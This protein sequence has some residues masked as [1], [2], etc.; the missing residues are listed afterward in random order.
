MKRGWALGGTLCACIVQFSE[1]AY[2]DQPAWN[3]PE[4]LKDATPRYPVP[5]SLDEEPLPSEAESPAPKRPSI[6]QTVILDNLV[7][8]STSTDGTSVVA[9]FTFAVPEGKLRSVAFLA[10]VQFRLSSIVT[11]GVKGFASTQRV[12]NASS[13]YTVNSHY[14][15]LRMGGVIRF[16][17]LLALWPSF[18]MGPT[19]LYSSS[20]YK[21]VVGTQVEIEAPFVFGLTQNVFLAAGPGMR[22][23]AGEVG[24]G[25][26][27][28]GNVRIG[29]TF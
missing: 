22:A 19:F 26:G 28:G 5:K 13:F 16:S 6:F 27:V 14:V 8:V 15:M 1:S 12:T 17:R 3:E 7:G 18:A 4:E 21:T 10:D 29:L 2:A 23:R 20:W 25:I 24:G 11:F 9:P